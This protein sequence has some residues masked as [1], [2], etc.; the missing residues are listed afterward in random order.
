MSFTSQEV[1][2]GD[3]S[4]LEVLSKRVDQTAH[5]SQGHHRSYPTPSRWHHH[6]LILFKTDRLQTVDCISRGLDVRV[7]A[8]EV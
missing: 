1:A 7:P 3:A 5:P 8:L 2:C 6:Q 4:E